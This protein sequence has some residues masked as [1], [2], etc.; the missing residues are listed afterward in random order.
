MSFET[1]AMTT[2]IGSHQWLEASRGL[3]I[4]GYLPPWYMVDI[5]LAPA[6]HSS[7]LTATDHEIPAPTFEE[8]VATDQR[9]EGIV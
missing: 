8:L 9:P 7:L 4:R 3:E 1:H 2:N 6:E 5:T